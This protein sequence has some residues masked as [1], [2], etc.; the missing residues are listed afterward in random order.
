MLLL[1]RA[2]LGSMMTEEMQIPNRFVGLS[3]Y[4]DQKSSSTIFSLN[5]LLIDHTALF[6]PLKH[7]SGEGWGR[8]VVEGAYFKFFG[9]KR[10]LIQG[11]VLNQGN[12]VNCDIIASWLAA[13]S[14]INL[15]Y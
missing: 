7:I 12:T 5:H 4:L 13:N 2:G 9:S 3:E 10:T 8:L 11:W 14:Q 15:Q 6:L 1:F